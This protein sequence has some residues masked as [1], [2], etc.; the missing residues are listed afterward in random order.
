MEKQEIQ[1][2]MENEVDDIPTTIT[3]KL[4]ENELVDF[5]LMQNS[6]ES[7]CTW[8]MDILKQNRGGTDDKF[9]FTYELVAGVVFDHENG[10]NMS[11]MKDA[12]WNQLKTKF[13]MIVT[14]NHV[15]L[16]S[17]V[18][19]IQHFL[20]G[21]FENNLDQSDS[22]ILSSI[23]GIELVPS[24]NTPQLLEIKTKDVVAKP[25]NVT[26]RQGVQVS[27]YSNVVLKFYAEDFIHVRQ[28]DPNGTQYAL[29]DNYISQNLNEVKQN[30]LLLIETSKFSWK[31][32]RMVT[33]KQDA[34]KG[35]PPIVRQV[36]IWELLMEEDFPTFIGSLVV[37]KSSKKRQ[38]PK[39]WNKTDG[40]VDEHVVQKFFQPSLI[41]LYENE[42][43][44]LFVKWMVK[45]MG[46]EVDN[47]SKG[48]MI[49][50]LHVL[51]EKFLI[52]F[53]IHQFPICY[54]CSQGKGKGFVWKGEHD[55]IICD[56]LW[57][58]PGRGPP[59]TSDSE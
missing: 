29:L 11:S 52:I 10:E 21:Y 36:Q 6:L 50:V 53:R 4:F 44:S 59:I 42:F 17:L 33:N 35:C 34:E 40:E 8:E 28:L 23:T 3:G 38:I 12:I 31:H 14:E 55:W 51:V 9:T 49:S 30:M 20:V 1:E 57:R 25:K 32:Y 54:Y 46:L 26:K 15:S 58:G 16:E 45:F 56:P 27:T 13:H 48:V 43:Q 22:I 24:S 19:L 37:F 5:N 47:D 41:L 39:L 18:R 2:I 7:M